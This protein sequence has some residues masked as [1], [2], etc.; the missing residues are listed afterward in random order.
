MHKIFAQLL[1][2]SP[3]K[4]D[5][6]QL[7]PGF[8]ACGRQLVVTNPEMTLG[9]HRKVVLSLYIVIVIYESTKF[10]RKDAQTLQLQICAKI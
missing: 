9:Q 8:V 7:R 5:L 1:C 4:S 3:L 10:G 6:V 2:S